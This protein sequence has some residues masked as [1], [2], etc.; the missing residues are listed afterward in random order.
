[1][2]V[3]PNMQEHVGVRVGKAINK[4][5]STI[6]LTKFDYILKLDADIILSRRYLEKS[7]NTRADLIGLGPF[8]LV[9]IKPFY[10]FTWR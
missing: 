3:K 9:K 5:L 4:A 8:M 2:Y 7:L 6:N 10:I 1:M